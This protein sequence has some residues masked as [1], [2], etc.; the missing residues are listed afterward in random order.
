M[1]KL[2]I[3]GYKDLILYP[4]LNSVK[5]FTVDIELEKSDG[6]VIKDEVKINKEHNMFFWGYASKEIEEFDLK[7]DYKMS[8]SLLKWAE[9]VIGV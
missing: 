3:K 1:A 5:H 6:S 8:E 7:N 4:E 9:R 2:K